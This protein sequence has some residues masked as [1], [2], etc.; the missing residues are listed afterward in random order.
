MINGK[1]I[2]DGTIKLSKID[3]SSNQSITLLGDTKISQNQ[4]P[5]NDIDLVN[6]K[7][8][9]DKINDFFIAINF[10]DVELFTYVSPE[11]FII[12]TIDN[13]SGITLDIKLNGLSYTLGNDIQLYDVVTILPNT[14]GFI[15]L[16]NTKKKELESSS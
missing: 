16:N 3:T 13:P 14:I 11:P 9:D 4:S 8:V 15:K 2:K 12:N 5:I 10:E 6:K 7:Y 1:Q